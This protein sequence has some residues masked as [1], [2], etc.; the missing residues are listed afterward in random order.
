VTSDHIG[1]R[2]SQMAKKWR[3]I[4]QPNTIFGY[5]MINIDLHTVADA[6]FAM[7][8]LSFEHFTNRIGIRN[9]NSH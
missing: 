5:F 7:E 2:S 6:K 1:Y 9:L 4:C 3:H 8:I